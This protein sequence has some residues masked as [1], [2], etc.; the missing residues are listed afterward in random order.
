MKVT[1][2]R[3]SFVKA[4]SIGMQMAGKAKGLSIL[5]NV[6]CT[7]KDNTA[8]I[9]SY[10]SEVA[11]TKRVP[12]VDSECDFDACVEPK[13]L[14][15]MLNSIKDAQV[16]MD[17][18]NYNCEI[19]HKKGVMSLPYEDTDEYPS[20][21]FDKNMKKFEVDAMQVY[22]WLKESRSFAS[23]NTLYPQMMGVYMYFEDGEF[24]VAATDSNVMYHDK[25]EYDYHDEPSNMVVCVK[26]INAVLPMINGY[27]KITIMNGDRNVVFR[28]DD[29]MLV[30]TKTELPY[31]RF[32][33]IIPKS[34]K[35]EV[36]IDKNEF[37][38]S[39]KRALIT[40]NEKTSL[41]KL[42]INSMMMSIHSDDIMNNKKSKDECPCTCIGGE[43]EIG[44]R[45]TYL[46][47]MMNTISSDRMKLM[48]NEPRTPVVWVDMLNNNK[49]LLQMPCS[50][51]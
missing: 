42:N 33:S 29:S 36:D 46:L 25:I 49:I 22:N 20:P 2:E 7:F 45:G 48:L 51:D 10:D 8:T 24:G 14:L 19:Q 5:E 21:I 23:V 30:A 1:I 6:K 3:E 34:Y 35:I 39:V 12:I 44:F 28:T 4:L 38:E 32:K 26:A 17:F 16:I 47:N 27:E 31:P 15:S 41:L 43:I 18:D 40:A 37:V 13:M 11:I 9:S 50:M